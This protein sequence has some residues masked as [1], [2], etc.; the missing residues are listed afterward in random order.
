MQKTDKNNNPN[1]YKKPTS[2]LFA[3]D[4][5]GKIGNNDKNTTVTAQNN[6]GDYGNQYAHIT[7]PNNE[8][9]GK[10]NEENSK[11]ISII[12][13][14]N[15]NLA[16]QMD[17]ELG[18]RSI[19][20]RKIADGIA[21]L[22][23]GKGLVFLPKNPTEDGILTQEQELQLE[24]ANGFLEIG[25]KEALPILANSAAYFSLSPIYVAQKPAK[26]NRNLSSITATPL[27]FTAMPSQAIRFGKPK[28]NAMGRVMTDIHA[29]HPTWGFTGDA[30]K[31]SR[32]KDNLEIVPISEYIRLEQSG[33]LPI[34]T[35]QDP[36]VLTPAFYIDIIDSPQSA[37]KPFISHAIFSSASI[38]DNAYPLPEWKT[39]TSIN[40][41]QGEAEASNVCIDFLRNGLHIFAVVNVYSKQFGMT[42]A[43]KTDGTEGEAWAESLDV[44]QNLRKSYNSGKL[45]VNPVYTDDASKDGKIEIEELKISFPVDA[46]RFFN[47]E[48]RAAILTAWGVMADLFGISKPEK[49]NLRS[50]GEFLQ[51]GIILLQSKVSKKQHSIED[52]INKLL[53]YYGLTEVKAHIQPEDNSTYLVSMKE[54][55]AEY[56]SINDVREKIMRAEPYTQEQLDKLALEKTRSTVA[57]LQAQ[58]ILVAENVPM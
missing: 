44:I 5:N 7:Q 43:D 38:F 28:M 14:G 33:K 41:I 9:D 4:K 46:V 55:A 1:G 57:D 50:Q 49:N 19:T 17:I 39:D 34:P 24:I 20:H 30:C 8:K 52:G 12:N 15:N 13:R 32:T 37:L 42:V 16:P 47:E 27:Y 54:F 56:M 25:L 35:T 58:G 18:K 53:E 10:V 11:V 36:N 21:G 40:Y 23:A 45:L 6:M 22:I 29:Y 48:S 51:T 3:W 31:D 26:F 2:I